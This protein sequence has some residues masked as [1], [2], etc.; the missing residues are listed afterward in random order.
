LPDGAP[1]LVVRLDEKNPRAVAQ[2]QRMGADLVTGITEDTRKMI[3]A[4][5]TEGAKNSTPPRDL[6]RQLIGN[7]VGNQRVGGLIGLAST[8]ADYVQSARAELAD[9][10]RMGNYFTRV[11]RDK[12]FDGTVR[13]A[14]DA[15]Q[16]L[17]KAT[18][19]RIAGAYSDRLLQLRGET[20][21]RTEAL[22]ALNAGK[23]EA[24]HQMV[25]SGQVPVQAVRLQWVSDPRP[26]HRD[27]HWLMNKDTVPLRAQFTNPLTGETL[28]YPGDPEAP[29]SET[30]NCAC[31][32]RSVVDYVEV[33][34]QRGT[35]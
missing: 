23:V 1:G 6:A 12:R 3:N 28:A 22:K 34:R 2:V 25:D 18:I 8:Q 21:G 26:T 5:L 33:A 15:G 19:D 14:M 10:E 20:I 35:L 4:V 29:G 32:T 17:D 16:P 11:R 9:P 13:K 24:V 27:G 7:K 31:F 30:I